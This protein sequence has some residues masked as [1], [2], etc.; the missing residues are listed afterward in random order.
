MNRKEFQVT[1]DFLSQQG[2]VGNTDVG[3][4]GQIGNGHLTDEFSEV[5]LRVRF[6]AVER[7]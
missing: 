7:N 4:A 3:F 1:V 2:N 5:F 6:V